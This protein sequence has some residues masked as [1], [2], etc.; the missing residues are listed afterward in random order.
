MH[1]LVFSH[2]QVSG[3]VQNWGGRTQITPDMIEVKAIGV[4]TAENPTEACKAA[5]MHT[6]SLGTFVAVE[7]NVWGVDM[8]ESSA[9]LLGEGDLTSPVP[10]EVVDD[11]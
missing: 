5:A 11:D 2:T 6:R 8:L 3:A 4:F 1:Y 9:K 7:A 10:A